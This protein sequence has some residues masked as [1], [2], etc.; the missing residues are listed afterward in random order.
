L[1]TAADTSASLWVNFPLALGFV[2]GLYWLSLQVDIRARSG[3]APQPALRRRGR[4]WSDDGA[5]ESP[6]FTAPVPPSPSTKPDNRWRE[7]VGSPVVEHAWETLCGSIIQEVC[8]ALCPGSK[9]HA[10][11]HARP[12][13]RV[14]L[15]GH[16]WIAKPLQVRKDEPDEMVDC[17]VL[18]S[19]V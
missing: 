19:T 13:A 2:G 17:K 12:A 11:M 7:Q 1:H 5:C 6:K 9:Q 10:C 8:S 4:K 16:K 15:D 14:T 3:S 18:M